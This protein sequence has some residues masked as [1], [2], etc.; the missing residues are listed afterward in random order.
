VNIMSQPSIA[1]TFE[2]N[3][4]AAIARQML[5]VLWAYGISVTVF[6]DGRW[7]AE[8]PRLVKRMAAEGHEIA[9]HTYTHPDLTQLDEDGIRDELQRTEALIERLTGQSAGC[10]LRPPYGAVNECV[11]RVV[12]EHGYQIVQR[13]AVDGGHWPGETTPER[14]IKRSLEYAADGAV[15]AYHLG[16]PL[17]L[18]A[19]PALIRHLCADGYR[20]VRLCDLPDVSERPAVH[21]AFADLAVEPGYLQVLTNTARAWSM[22]LTE[23]GAWANQKQDAPVPVIETER[24]TL[25]VITGTVVDWQ[26]ARRQDRYFAVLHGEAICE[27]RADEGEVICSRAIARAGDIVLWAGGYELRLHPAARGEAVNSRWIGLILA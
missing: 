17:T 6:L 1:L 2:S 18:A 9:N 4:L 26:P 23:F 3:G 19:L 20:L 12:V 5:D 10:W 7:G 25:A 21:P 24:W 14:I 27:F 8:N 16:S 15:L 22:N 13:N 11:R